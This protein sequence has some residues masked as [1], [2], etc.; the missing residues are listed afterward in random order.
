MADAAIAFCE[1]IERQASRIPD[2]VA[3]DVVG[4]R[5]YSWQAYHQ[6][7]LR[8]SA[9]L[10]GLGVGAGDAV[11]SMLP[12]GFHA[13]ALWAGCSWLGAVEVPVHSSNRG[14]WLSDIVGRIGA[15]VAVVDASFWPLWAE[16]VDDSPVERVIVVDADAPP[17]PPGRVDV[18]A[19]ADLLATANPARPSHAAFVH[20][21]ACVLHTSGTTGSSKGVMLPWSTFQFRAQHSQFPAWARTAES[22]FYS[23]LPASHMSARRPWYEGAVQG[24]RVVLRDSFKTDRWLP[25][26]RAHGC[27][28]TPLVGSMAAFLMAQPPAPDDHDNPARLVLM[29]PVIPAVDEFKVRFG[30]EEVLTGYGMTEIPHIFMAPASSA[31]FRSVGRAIPGVPFRLV[32]DDGGDVAP[33]ETGELLVGGDP[34]CANA[35]Y[36]EMPD[37]T[38][39]AWRGGWFHTGDMFSV[40]DDGYYYFVDRRKDAIRRRGEN[41]SS[42]EVEAVVNADPAVAECAVV[43]VPSEWGEEEI[44]L[45]VVATPD[46]HVD[47]AALIARIEPQLARYAVPRYVEV[48]ESLP[49]TPNLKVR[50][51]I[52]RD[53]GVGAST[54]DG[55]ANDARPRTT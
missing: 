39:Q 23:P 10:A 8:W 19:S 46:Q 54:W 55:R 9:A 31:R 22:V 4:D 29:G 53:K 7:G 5:S 6:A 12:T 47:P 51:A 11:L 18:I 3:V 28:I 26:V 21:I 45:V 15:R 14:A 35:G 34:M 40:D 50:K 41:I 13:A 20:D 52:L 27:T 25:D 38:E 42:L 16:L 30:V 44:L 1:L 48:V 32:D 49:K 17:D 36:Y 2:D 43:G 33:G 37:A 24:S